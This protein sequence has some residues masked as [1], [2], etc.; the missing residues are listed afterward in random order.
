MVD[1]VSCALLLNATITANPQIASKVSG[2]SI[3]FIGRASISE[4]ETVIVQYET[5]LFQFCAK[6]TSKNMV[7]ATRTAHTIFTQ[8]LGYSPAMLPV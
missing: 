1:V 5:L 3:L 2:S 6:K 4:G 7:I 8:L